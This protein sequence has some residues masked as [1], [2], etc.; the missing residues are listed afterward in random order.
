MPDKS[1]KTV[2]A[3][4]RLTAD[5]VAKI[6]ELLDAGC[7]IPYISRYHK[8]LA[9]SLP[10]ES[11]H[12]LVEERKR[13]EKLGA[14]RRKI[15]KKLTE[16]EILT[17]DLEAKINRANDMRELVDYYVPFR[18]RK[19]SRSRQA[20][21]QG[22]GALATE[23]LSQDEFISDM[24]QAAQPHIDPELGLET[25]ADVLEGV[26]HVVTDWV[27]E[28]KSH[29]DRQRQVFRREAVLVAGRAG[30]SLPGRLAREF[31]TYFDYR[32][33]AAKV[34]P[35]HMLTILRGKRFKALHY[36]LEPPMEAMSRA[37]A[38]LY[39][40]GGVAQLERIQAELGDELP[41]DDG[42]KLAGLNGAE[43]LA[44]CIQYSLRHI[45]ADI[46]ARELDKDLCKAAEDMALDIVG[47]NLRS[48]LMAQPLPKRMLGI[49]PG[50][51]TGCN[52][53]AVDE[54]GNVIETIT[55]YPHPPQ[56]DIAA[57]TE[58]MSRLIA[59]H[60]LEVVVIGEATG[61]Q[62]TEALI[63]QLIAEG[64]AD[65]HYTVLAEVGLDAYAT[66]RAARSDLPDIQAPER[67]AVAL[68]RRVQDPL[69]ELVKVNPRELCP[70]PYAED[71][72]GGALKRVL[73]TVIE[74]CVCEVGVDVNKAHY[75]LLRYIPGFG[76]DKAVEVVAHRE[77]NGPLTDRA[78][79]RDVPKI[80]EQSYEQA[81][82]FL[83][84][85]GAAN[86]LDGTRIHPRFYPVAED[87]CSHLEIPLEDLKTEEGRQ[88][89]REHSGEIKLT[90]LEKRFGVH[91]LVLKDILTELGTPWAD[92]RSQGQPPSLR[93]KVLVL[94]DLQPEEWFI[95]TVRNIVDFGVFIDLGVGEDGLV[96][97][98]ELSDKFVES[99]YD[100]VSVGDKVRVRVVRIDEEKGRIALSMRSE[101][102]ARARPSRE[103][104]RRREARPA[105]HDAPRPAGPARDRRPAGHVHVPHSTAGTR[106][107][108]VERAAMA[109]QEA[110][111]KEDAAADGPKATPAADGQ[112]DRKDAEPVSNMGDMLKNLDF[113][114]IERRGEASS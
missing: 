39:F 1:L 97:I 99:P 20:L 82:G 9:G 62:E 60:Q 23:V 46:T 32:Q 108:R 84:V 28:E 52:L 75:S 77:K 92:P 70:E 34:H 89:M 2:A 56:S 59:E 102:S 66:S 100:I 106:S 101:S 80:D 85:P 22:L 5:Q 26:F 38:E 103:P 71:V 29:R 8:E 14:R 30:R 79:L 18:P 104:R 112:P 114:N 37:A 95:G 42:E 54:N 12:E 105:R 35:Y 10:S 47:R 21:A 58:T 72:D 87:V 45:L 13:L 44:A 63:T 6:L 96:H 107:R 7:S 111:A 61:S 50:Y 51:R 36:H 68:C 83:R 90:D 74:E 73:D 19:R 3:K 16:R 40:S 41:A 4:Y 11:F 33:P 93:Q 98:S 27:A 110:K 88:R 48:Q 86:P 15:L 64:H 43:L 49:H 57:A 25:V 109:A 94:A 53:A 24:G 31:R 113:A 76:P 69:S 17:E 91:Y 67:C 65:L 78:Q 81:I 55:V